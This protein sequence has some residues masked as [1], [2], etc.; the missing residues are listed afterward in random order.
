[1]EAAVGEGDLEVS[2]STIARIVNLVNIYLI[3]KPFERLALPLDEDSFIIMATNSGLGH[4][5]AKGCDSAREEGARM[6]AS[7]PIAQREHLRTCW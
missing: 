7:G 3:R 5:P 4:S 1:M 2:R 6:Q